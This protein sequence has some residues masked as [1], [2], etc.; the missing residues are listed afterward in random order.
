MEILQNHIFV[1]LSMQSQSVLKGVFCIAFCRN[2]E[3]W[4][5]L[6]IQKVVQTKMC[7]RWQQLLKILSV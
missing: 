7:I 3:K 5:L 2:M 4:Y 1:I 6:V